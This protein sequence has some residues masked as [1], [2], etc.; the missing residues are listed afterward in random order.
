MALAVCMLAGCKVAVIVVEGGQVESGESGTCTPEKVC[1]HEVNDTDYKQ[2]FTAVAAPGWEFVKWTNGDFNLCNNSTNPDCVI[3]STL[4]KGNPG[5]EAVIASNTTFFILPLFQLAPDSVQF[6]FQSTVTGIEGNL[7][8][9]VNIDDTVTF[10]VMV[11]SEMRVGAS[12]AMAMACQDSYI[13]CFRNE[14]S[15]PEVT[16]ETRYSS[17]HI[18]TGLINRIQIRNGGFRASDEQ[19]V[20]IDYIRFLYNADSS[21][22]VFQVDDYSGA[23]LTSA[24]STNLVTAIAGIKQTDFDNSAMFY[25]DWFTTHY[26]ADTPQENTIVRIAP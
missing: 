10:T 26:D 19:D 3:D 9:G 17:G 12:E 5:L 11:P 14:W 22:T 23:W 18:Q 7:P 20:A 16:Y 2:T 25:L 13:Q 24:L 1:V 21:E 4:S 15:F 6:T 8:E